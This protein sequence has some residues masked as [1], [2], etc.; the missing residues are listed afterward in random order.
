MNISYLTQAL[1]NDRTQITKGVDPSVWINSAL[2][3][4]KVTLSFQYFVRWDQS[5]LLLD[6]HVWMTRLVQFESPE[7]LETSEKIILQVFKDQGYAAEFYSFL[8]YC[9]RNGHT[10]ACIL[11]PELP[12]ELLDEKKPVWVIRAKEGT[13]ELGINKVTISRLK[14]QIQS[15][16]GGPIRMGSK[17]LTYGTSAVEC[18]L[19]KTDAAYPGDVDCVISTND[20][21]VLGMIE[22]KK[23]TIADKI[24]NHLAAH[25]YQRGDKRKYDRL[26]CLH[27]YYESTYPNVCPITMLYFSTRTPIIRM[28]LIDVENEI[29][30]VKDSNDVDITKLSNQDIGNSILNFMGIS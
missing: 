2:P 23:H 26:A 16:S 22:F 11:L 12:L 30:V 10:L 29:I 25:Y 14:E 28:Q 21:T 17:G 24:E 20:G 9:K 6:A 4:D 27:Q 13:G 1:C 8:A 19:S 3:N 5:P 15:H 18:Y 7:E